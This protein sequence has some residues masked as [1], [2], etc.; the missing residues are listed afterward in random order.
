MYHI[1]L[2]INNFVNNNVIPPQLNNGIAFP[3]GLNADNVIAHYTP[4]KTNAEHMGPSRL[5]ADLHGDK[6]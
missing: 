1:E 6:S 5:Y 4:I 2:N 3:I